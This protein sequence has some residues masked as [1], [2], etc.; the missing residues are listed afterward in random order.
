M[1]G[2]DPV[3]ARYANRA[4]EDRVFLAGHSAR[5]QRPAQPYERLG[6]ETLVQREKSAEL[7]IKPHTPWIV[8]V[9]FQMNTMTFVRY[10]NN[11]KTI[12]PK[13]L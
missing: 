9:L 6:A 10:P 11:P 2:V 1:A 12:R 8:P 3:I 7:D 13:I 5:L 4:V